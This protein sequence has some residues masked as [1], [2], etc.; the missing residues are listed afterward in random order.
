MTCSLADC[1]SPSYARGWCKKHYARYLRNGDPEL[2][3]NRPPGMSAEDVFRWY[4]PGEPP[5]QDCWLWAGGSFH[6]DGYGLV[7]L[8]GKM[9]RAHVLAYELFVGKIPDGHQIRHQ[10]DNPPCVHPRHLLTGTAL[11]NQRD[12]VSRNRQVR[13]ERA[14]KAKLTAEQ[15]VCVRSAH[16]QG[17]TQA[18][19]AREYDLSQASISEIT[20]QESWKHISSTSG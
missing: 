11:D 2:T 13:G 6:T 16:A 5:E 4:M 20:R 7:S 1:S 12:K 19:L 9:A 18:E 10:C 17:V 15:V 3:V 14:P 8:G